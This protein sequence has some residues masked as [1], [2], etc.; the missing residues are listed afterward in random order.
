MATAAAAS[1]DP[2]GPI[3]HIAT[4]V[5]DV[6]P[7]EINRHAA[8]AMKIRR[9]EPL[10]S[11]AVPSAGIPPIVIPDEC[12]FHDSQPRP[13]LALGATSSINTGEDQDWR[14]IRK[15]VYRREP[16]GRCGPAILEATHG[17]NSVADR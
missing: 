17:V 5:E 8:A 11:R 6:P 7:E 9:P 15:V 1:T 10:S 16:V 12:R 13:G 2:F 4:H 3:W 14:S